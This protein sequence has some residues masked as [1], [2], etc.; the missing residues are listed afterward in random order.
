M[1]LLC[2]CFH[3]GV[4]EIMMLVKRILGVITAKKARS[5]GLLY[6]IAPWRNYYFLRFF[7]ASPDMAVASNTQKTKKYWRIGTKIPG[8]SFC[9]P[10]WNW[11]YNA[12]TYQNNLGQSSQKWASGAS[13]AED[14][15]YAMPC[16]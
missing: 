16:Q 8:K 7:T 15:F 2:L 6:A 10:N 4:T 9:P 1:A 3:C 14:T 12:Q 5:P 13:P 11:I